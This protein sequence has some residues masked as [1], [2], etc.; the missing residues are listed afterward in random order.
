MTRERQEGI[1]QA[2]QDIMAELHRSKRLH[3]GWPTNPFAAL[4]IIGGEYGEACQ[5]A[6]E[7]HFRDADPCH[8]YEEVLQIAATS[9]LFAIDY[10]VRKKRGTNETH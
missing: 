1:Y 3:P 7:T 9:I 8:V 5:A 6:I 4:C 2:M 10:Q